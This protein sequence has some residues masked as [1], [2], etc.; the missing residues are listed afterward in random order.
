MVSLDAPVRNPTGISVIRAADA[1]LLA[2][3]MDHADLG[4]AKKTIEMVGPD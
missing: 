1:A 3:E 4:S 2:I